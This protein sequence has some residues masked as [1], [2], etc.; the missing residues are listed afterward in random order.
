MSLKKFIND[1]S[2]FTYTLEAILGITLILGTVLFVTGNIPNTAQK[3]EEHSKV[4]LVN[5]GRDA[6]DL[7][8]LTPITDIF[9][10][11]SKMMGVYRDYLLVANKKY[12]E[13]G[14][15]VNFTVFYLDT[16][17]IVY[18]N[19]TLEQTILGLKTP[20]N[21]TTIYGN[22][23]W[24]FLNPGEYNFKAF[25]G[26][27]SDP[28]TWSNYVTVK[29]GDYFLESDI[30]GISDVGDRNVSGVVFLANETG[31][32][33]LNIN[34]LDADYKEVDTLPPTNPV[35]IT[36]DLGNFSFIWPNMSGKYGSGT[37]Y[38]Q[39]KNNITG[40][41]S[42]THRIIYSG[43][44]GSKGTLC[45]NAVI[46]ETESVILKINVSG[47]INLQELN[48]NQV[49]YKETGGS[50]NDSIVDKI[51]IDFVNPLCNSPGYKG[52]CSELIFTGYIAGDYYI[53]YGNTAMGKGSEPKDPA[54]ASKTNG[55]LVRVLPLN[56]KCLFGECKP[57]CSGLNMT[58][59]SIYMDR[60]VPEYVNYNLYLINPDGTLCLDCP[61]F[62]EIING[63]PTDE[64]A[65]VNKLFHLKTISTE[66]LRELRMVLWYK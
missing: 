53:F 26:T 52:D 55:I 25:E 32:P 58:N 19:L 15:P 12:A 9:G 64:A 54:A 5:I 4:Q 50:V 62:Q 46:N 13:P 34:L 1:E 8:E 30:Y 21:S 56:G 61:E 48:I 10:S 33:G 16:S 31:A 3:T 6:L 66:Y 63:Y 40:K 44:S 42:N 29:I 41:V 60:F 59:L 24:S 37:Y 7:V 65:T 36:S 38:I 43:G 17:D 22:K 27:S 45:C 2:G 47:N 51:K 39:A 23:T 35:N 20:V 14:E 18:K 28:I 11:Y 57:K 49:F